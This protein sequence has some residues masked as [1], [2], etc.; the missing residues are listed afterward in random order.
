[1]TFVNPR[2]RFNLRPPFLRRRG[3]R[4]KLEMGEWFRPFLAALVP[5]RRLR[6][7]PLDPFGRTEVR[8]TERELIGWYEALLDEVVRELTAANHPVALQ[9]AGAPD[10]IRGYEEVKLRNVRAVREY[11]Q[12]KRAELRRLPASA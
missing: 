4:R 2:V 8:R 11:V 7:G 12:Q 3:L 9:L 5:L 10:R 1:M 6:G